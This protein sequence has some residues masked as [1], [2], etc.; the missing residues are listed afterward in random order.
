MIVCRECGHHNP[1][2][3][4]FCE[5][6]DCGAFLEWAGEVVDQGPVSR[7]PG[8][9]RPGPGTLPD[10]GQDGGGP[11]S[12]GRGQVG[13]TV[14]LP[15]RELQVEPGEAVDCQVT[16]TNTGQIVDQY[17]IQVFG[18]AA[19]W[20]V[21]EPPSVNLVPDAEGSAKV[22]FRPPRRPELVAGLRPFRLVVTSR[23]DLRAVAFVDGTVTV[24]AFHESSAWLQPT[25]AEGRSGSYEV[26]VENRGNAPVVARLEAADP[27]QALLL[28]VSHPALEVPPG[29]RRAARVQVQPRQR[30][31]SGEPVTYPFRVVAQ[32]GWDSPRGLDAQFVH[33]PSLPPIGRGW[34]R[35][36]LTLLGALMMVGGAFATW[37]GDVDGLDLTYEGYVEGV[38]ESDVPSPP[39]G[40]SDTFVS[41]GLVAVVLGLLAAL[42]AVTR[43]GRLTRVSAGLAALLLA[44]FAF[45]VADA[46]VPIGTGTWVAL[47]GAILALVGGV[48]AIQR[49]G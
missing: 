6:R 15:E 42:G 10:R 28:G 29:S 38:F 5:N 27:R 17:S 37:A 26:V 35:I 14:A 4:S 9:P 47:L 18:D 46:D 23:E 13:L 8:P 7:P 41:V 25:Y 3:T 33:R 40:L 22:T 43:T 24:G 20:T 45:T 49:T 11:R 44:V 34:W 12:V 2:G 19:R 48:L 30:P 32:V 16:V 39:D 36:L 21:V 31:L 1:P